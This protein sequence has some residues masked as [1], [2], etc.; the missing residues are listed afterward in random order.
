MVFP[1]SCRS[2]IRVAGPFSI[3]T[4]QPLL[5]SP[6]FGET[7]AM[8]SRIILHAGPH[9]TGSTAMQ[10]ALFGKRETL[11]RQGIVYPSIGV[12][13][14]A[15]HDLVDASRGWTQRSFDPEAFKREMEQGEVGIVSS[16]NIV[17]LDLNGLK[18]LAGYLPCKPQKVVY[19]LRRLPDLWVSHWQEL[20]KHGVFLT[21][22]EYLACA[23]KYIVGGKNTAIDQLEQLRLLEGVFG[24]DALYIIGY[25]ALRSA[26]VDFGD[27]L[28]NEIACPSQRID[29]QT[30]PHVNTSMEMWTVELIRLLNQIHFESTSKQP[31]FHIQAT[32]VRELAKKTLP[33]ADDFK[34]VVEALSWPVTINNREKGV[35]DRQARVIRA[36]RDRFVGDPDNVIAHYQADT[37]KTVMTFKLPATGYYDLR[38][39]LADYYRSLPEEVRA[40]VD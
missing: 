11:A 28:L 36:Y 20:V 17:H 5:D 8:V 31:K 15:H 21:F 9:K 29:I 12:R 4:G 3:K 19:Y 37:A 40:S 18:K 35:M 13:N 39:A 24:R 10:N 22:H 26:D 16:E 14:N 2:T 32:V 23:A 1:L 6:L 34:K 30:A 38:V 7:Q 33:F 25:D 27:Y